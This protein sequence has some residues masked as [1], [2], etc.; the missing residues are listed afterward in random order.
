MKFRRMVD[1][2]VVDQMETSNIDFET[3]EAMANKLA[4]DK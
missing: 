4:I 2:R 1:G 3:A